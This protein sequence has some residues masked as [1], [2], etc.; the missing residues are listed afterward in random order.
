MT[1]AYCHYRVTRWRYYHKIRGITAGIG[2]NFLVQTSCDKWNSF[3]ISKLSSIRCMWYVCSALSQVSEFSAKVAAVFIHWFF[4][5][6][7]IDTDWWMQWH[8]DQ[9]NCHVSEF[10][11]IMWKGQLVM[12]MEFNV[13]GIGFQSMGMDGDGVDVHYRVT[14]RIS[15][16][17]RNIEQ[18]HSLIHSLANCIQNALIPLTRFVRWKLH[19]VFLRFYILY[20]LFYASIYVVYILWS[21]H[22]CL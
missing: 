19:M 12:G 18:C 14:C 7:N 15:H 6:C 3:I 8:K 10:Y 21:H 9:K 16:H 1:G 11:E 13:V 4:T 22:A 20:I 2:K 5:N 17:E